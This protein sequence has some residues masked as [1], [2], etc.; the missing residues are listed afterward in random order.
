MAMPRLRAVGP[1]LIVAAWGL[2]MA[3]L[4]ALSLRDRSIPE[5]EAIRL[6]EEFVARNGYTDLP[7]DADVRKLTPE[8]VVLWSSGKE[9][10]EHRHD[11]L[12]RKADGAHGGA[13]G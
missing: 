12:A 6:A 7:P 1:W 8:P 11:T 10:L 4:L 13:G 2:V 5:S 3:Y 9:E